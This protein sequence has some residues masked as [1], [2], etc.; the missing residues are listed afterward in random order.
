MSEQQKRIESE[1]R[2]REARKQ[3]IE[4]ERTRRAENRKASLRQA[5]IRRTGSDEGFEA[6][7]QRQQADEARRDVAA[8]QR[9]IANEYKKAF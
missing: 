1:N 9:K 7:F 2:R 3:R 5:Y 8:T 6:E 4:D